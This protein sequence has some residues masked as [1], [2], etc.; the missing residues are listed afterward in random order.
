M[1]LSFG[2]KTN[3]FYVLFTEAGENALRAARA[4]EARFRDYPGGTTQAEIE[5]CEHEGDRIT[6]EL[7]A[8]TNSQFIIPRCLSFGSPVAARI[9]AMS[10]NPP[11][12]P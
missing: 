8:L 1:K 2:P 6:G 3:E 7:I 11:D 12:P 9:G 5:E 4:A 10:F